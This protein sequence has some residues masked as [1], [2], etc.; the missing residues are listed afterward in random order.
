MLMAPPK[1]SLSQ[2]KTFLG[3]IRNDVAELM[4]AVLDSQPSAMMLMDVATFDITYANAASLALLRP[5]AHLLPVPVD[6]VVG[7]SVDIFHKVPE[8]QRALLANPKNL[9]FTTVVSLGNETLELKI[10]PIFDRQGGYHAAC[11]TWKVVT[12]AVRQAHE[13]HMRLQMLDA[14]PVSVLLCDLN[15][16]ITY[17][18]E[19]ALATLKTI[20]HLLP[21]KADEVVGQS[22]DIFH[23]SPAHQR[24]I[25]ATLK[26]SHKAV[27]RLGDEYLELIVSPVT[28]EDGRPLG[29]M[30]TWAVVTDR[31]NVGQSVSTMTEKLMGIGQ[32][33]QAQAATGAAAAEETSAQ[34]Q[35]L[36]AATEQLLMSIDEI[37]ENTERAAVLSSE[38]LSGMQTV[39]ER[40]ATLSQASKDIGEVVKLINDIA[41]QTNLLALNATIE[42]ARAGEAGKG[43]AVVANE[44]K[45]LARQTA[46]STERISQSIQ[47]VQ[48]IVTDCLQQAS[49]VLGQSK[50]MSEITTSISAAIQ[51]QSAATS[52]ISNSIDHVYTAATDTSQTA[53]KT[54]EAA[55]GLAHESEGLTNAVQQFL[56]E[57]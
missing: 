5:I 10:T 56:A 49:A 32:T 44:V 55:D 28:E 7:S 34:S 24:G 53:A 2:G 21:C 27:V 26:G 22:Y 1:S 20:E 47:E 25:M 12:E 39:H 36:K 6:A 41:S 57:R 8:R 42:A 51:E 40:I 18:N 33:L 23:K 54:L 31:V 45:T 4:A 11:L 15:S 9:P 48:S 30:L 14:M 19:T 13:A 37:G 3:K 29:A 38:S 52:E 46:S 17:A 43:F 50:S 16:T 35:S